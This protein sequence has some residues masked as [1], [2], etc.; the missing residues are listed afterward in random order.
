MKTKLLCLLVG[1]SLV[2][3]CHWNSLAAAERTWTDQQGRTVMADFIALTGETVSL[4]LKDGRQADLPLSRLSEADQTF[5]R[6]LAK[7]GT[8]TLLS[9]LPVPRT[10][11]ESA[12][13]IDKLIDSHLAAAR[14]PANPPTDDETFVR[15]IYLDVAGRI[16]TH[17]ETLK[18]L[19]DKTKEKRPRLIRELLNSKGHNSHLFN[20]FADL[21]R[22]KTQ[23]SE[24][25]SGASYV[26]WVR[27]CV[28][29]NK[30]Y[31]EMVN[32][33][34][35]ATGNSWQNPASGYL[36]RD[37]GMPLDNMALTMQ[38][39]AGLDISC[40]QCHDHPFTETSQ[41][42]FYK[43][44][45]F[46]GESTTI[47][48][49]PERKEA[50]PKSN[51]APSKRI[52]EELKAKGQYPQPDLLMRRMINAHN[53]R[54][55]DDKKLTL[56]LPIDYKYS[57]GK[58]GD[59]VEPTVIYGTPAPLTQSDTRRK[60]FAAWLTGPENERFAI[61]IA[62][63]MWKRAFGRGLAEPIHS[64]EDYGETPYALLLKYL[65][66]EMRRL[67]FDLKAFEE[68]ILN[69]QAYQR[70]AFT[71]NVDMGAAYHFPGP[72]LR[73]MSSE[74]I[75]DSFLTMILPDPDYFYRKRDYKDWESLVSTKNVDDMTGEEARDF[76]SKR[77]TAL[78]SRPGG[79]YGWPP[80]SDDDKNQVV[81][82]EQIQ[83]FR[84]NSNVLIRASEF[85]QPSPNGVNFL[86]DLGQSDR[87]L[88]DNGGTWGSVPVV[89]ALM[90]SNGTKNL[91]K[92]G[93]RILDAID[94]GRAVGPKLETAF[95][96]ILNRM[97]NADER[98]RAYKAIARDGAD[99]FRNV[100]WALINTRE[101]FFVQ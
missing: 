48:N 96:S 7:Q 74:Q 79:N 36:L 94:K 32:E 29:K 13:N 65:G 83:A 67:K 27:D 91:T 31:D 30:P 51:G 22:L 24:Y 10:P 33:M 76:L 99:G 81:F 70:Q 45:A 84:M 59:V 95:L 82:D 26:Q 5:A 15:R 72:L 88:I 62:N 53:Y 17:D 12:A 3:L 11:W 61:T 47:M 8:N 85:P 73:R 2:G 101:F 90:N 19:E 6:D 66:S 38:A 42:Q 23:A 75:W 58:P 39:F 40:A 50:Y 77:I 57:D 49:G 80:V 20:Y 37:A 55:T 87:M 92:S 97:P 54:V 63:R 52:E 93:S 56:K 43:L 86:R 28:E 64:I 14:V 46:F 68:I 9:R 35:T 16:P 34:L 100:V 71:G 4:R 18:F 41:M 89:L 21:L 78:T 1:S 98:S 44:A 25:V 69:T 60:A